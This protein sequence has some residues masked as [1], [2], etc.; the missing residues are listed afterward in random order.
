VNWGSVAE[1][2]CEVCGSVPGS[3]RV[4]V[5][6]VVVDVVVVEVVGGSVVVVETDDADL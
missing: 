5:V 6:V 3:G 2:N 4:V 1:G